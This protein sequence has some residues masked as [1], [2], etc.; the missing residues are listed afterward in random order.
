VCGYMGSAK[1]PRAHGNLL[2]GDEKTRGLRAPCSDVHLIWGSLRRHTFMV[3]EGPARFGP[4]S[5]AVR[6]NELFDRQNIPPVKIP[7]FN[8]KRSIVISKFPE[9]HRLLAHITIRKRCVD[10]DVSIVVV[11]S[12]DGTVFTKLQLCFTVRNC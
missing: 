5:I 10:Y 9:S 11:P 1:Q 12:S 4:S 2:V 8:L 6:V 3:A 7:Q